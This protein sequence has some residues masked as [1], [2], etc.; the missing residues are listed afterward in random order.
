MKGIF[1]KMKGRVGKKGSSLIAVMTAMAVLSIVALCAAGIAITNYRTT[2]TYKSQDNY[3]YSAEAG[4]AQFV[5][6]INDVAYSFSSEVDNWTEDKVLEL[7]STILGIEFDLSD[8]VYNGKFT[9]D[10]KIDSN[11]TVDANN[12]AT[13]TII[14]TV[15]NTE[16]NSTQEYTSTIKIENPLGESTVTGEDFINVK[17]DTSDPLMNNG[18]GLVT[19]GSYKNTTWYGLWGGFNT[20]QTNKGYKVKNLKV[21]SGWSSTTV[22][23]PYYNATNTSP[24]NSLTN[25][26]KYFSVEKQPTSKS[27]FVNSAVWLKK[28][29]NESQG[30]NPD[31]YS[32]T[33]MFSSSS[34][35]QGGSQTKLDNFFDNNIQ[36]DVKG[37]IDAA[38]KNTEFTKT[39]E[40]GIVLKYAERENSQ[41]YYAKYDGNKQFFITF[42]KKPKDTAL[43][44]LSAW[45]TKSGI[46]TYE[47]FYRVT[48]NSSKSSH[49]MA[50]AYT[51]TDGSFVTENTSY[52]LTYDDHYYQNKWFFIDL[53]KTN[54][55]L[56]TLYLSNSTSAEKFYDYEL[57]NF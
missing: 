31:N 51:E 18:Y 45:K 56:G 14:T 39:Y 2:Q 29:Q 40:N 7:Y 30:E 27:D 32:H 28:V 53:E 48:T 11:Y 22:T 24:L 36:V 54:G 26:A 8:T 52:S 37:I 33:T 46:D 6:H 57:K 3:Y 21:S 17:M 41:R 23:N 4:Q 35:T 42:D 10:N 1:K 43:I 38:K 50:Y 9:V 44:S 13:F 20:F 34:T 16:D 5:S 55:S 12:V 19:G 47:P 25:A 15:T 49:G